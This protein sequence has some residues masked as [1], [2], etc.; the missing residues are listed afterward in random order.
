MCVEQI[1]ALK[2]TLD[3]RR[4]CGRPTFTC[5][6]DVKKAFDRVWRAGEAMG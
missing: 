6:I 2:E 4:R 5:F 1:F 3:R